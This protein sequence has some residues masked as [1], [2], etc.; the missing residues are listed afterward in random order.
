MIIILTTAFFINT[1]IRSK[2]T[3]IFR[4]VLTL[5][6]ILSFG[7]TNAQ[8][9]YSQIAKHAGMDD[10]KFEKIVKKI[11]KIESTTGN[12]NTRNKKSGAYGRYQIMPQT[13]KLY[14][15][16]LGIPYGKWKIP[17]N[18]DR[19]FRAILKDNIQALKKN[20]IKITAFTIYGSHQQGAGGFNAIMKNKKL[21][22]HIEK[23]IRNNLP[24]KLRTIESSKLAMV[25]KN[26]WEK[27]LA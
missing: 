4:P 17:E 27:E 11:V 5:L 26:Y 23:N 1:T 25:W 10:K 20:G 16:K 22:K 19:I 8:A 3:T 9:A 6:I 12:Y 7:A 14:T 2:L 15:K 24:K 18:Q 13:A 21:T